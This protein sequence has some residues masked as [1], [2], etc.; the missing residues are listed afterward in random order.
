MHRKALLAEVTRQSAAYLGD[1]LMAWERTVNSSPAL[2]KELRL[3]IDPTA[4]TLVLTREQAVALTELLARLDI[5]GSVAV[6]DRHGESR[7]P[8]PIG[9]YSS[10]STNC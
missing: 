6:H 8:R 7:A 3:V 10:G 1:V 5:R 2:G 4:R 9:C